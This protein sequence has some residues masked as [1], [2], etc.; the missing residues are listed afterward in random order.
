MVGSGRALFEQTCREGLEGVVAK[1]LRGKYLP[2]KR[3]DSW[4][5]IKSRQQ[6][7]CLIIGYVP[8]GDDISSLIIEMSGVASAPA[9]VAIPMF[10]F[11]G[12]LMAESGTPGRL[13]KLTRAA[14]GWL[15]GGIAIVSVMACAFFTAFTGASGGLILGYLLDRYFDTSP[16]LVMTIT[17]L[18]LVGA[19]FRLIQTLRSFSDDK[20]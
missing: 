11:A 15:P 3:S 20:K 5:K 6:I 13:I 14:V 16:W 17:L 18:A 19:F 7:Y 1:R 2:G 10:T 12:Y 4:I 8:D 9:L